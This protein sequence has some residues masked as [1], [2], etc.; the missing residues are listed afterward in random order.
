MTLKVRKQKEET[1]ITTHPT[2]FIQPTT[3]KEE[4]PDTTL[5]LLKWFATQQSHIGRSLGNDFTLAKST[6]GLT[7]QD[8]EAIKELIHNAYYNKRL[9]E[10]LNNTPTWTWNNTKNQWE[11]TTPNE[12][13]QKIINEQAQTIFNTLTTKITATAMLNRNV[14]DNPLFQ[15]IAKLPNTTQEPETEEKTMMTTL[16]KLITPKQKNTTEEEP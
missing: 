5:E 14:P 13:Q 10:T 1:E 6:G 11:Q 12:T 9:T 2:Y 3:Q 7:E 8:K 4:T 15:G 16:K